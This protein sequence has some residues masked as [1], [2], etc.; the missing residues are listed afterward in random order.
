MGEEGKEESRAQYRFRDQKDDRRQGELTLDP[1]VGRLKADMRDK[2]I[3]DGGICEVF[4]D[5]RCARKRGE[6]LAKVEG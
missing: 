4:V 1:L 6:L 5:E 2:I 3:K